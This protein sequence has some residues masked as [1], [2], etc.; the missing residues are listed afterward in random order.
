MLRYSFLLFLFI[1]INAFVQGQVTIYSESFETDGEGTRYTSNTFV[2][3]TSQLGASDFF[4]RTNTNPVQ[5]PTCP[6]PKF[7]ST[8]TGLQGSFFWASEDIRGSTP[9]NTFP[10]GSFVT[11]SFNI[12]GY[13]TLKVS[14]YLATSN[15]NG[16]RW[17]STDSINIKAKI[18]GGNEILVGRFMGTATFGGN[19]IIDANLNGV[20]DAGSESS[21]LCDGVNFTKYTFNIPGTGTNMQVILDFDQAGGTEELAIDLIEV[22]GLTAPG[23]CPNTN[24]NFFCASYNATSLTLNN[25][26]HVCDLV[27]GEYQDISGLMAGNTYRLDFCGIGS[28]PAPAYN[29]LLTVYSPSNTLVG[30]NDD[31]CGDD[32]QFD[33]VAPAS[34]TYRVLANISGNCGATNFIFTPLAITLLATA[35]APEINVKGNGITINDEDISPSIGD[36]TSFG[37]V[38]ACNGTIVKSFR[39]LNSGSSNLTVSGINFIGTHASDYTLTSSPSSP[40]I[41]GD[42]TTFQVTFN[43]SAVGLRT[44]TLNIVNNDGNENPYNFSIEGTGNLSSLSAFITGQNNVL[45]FGQSTG[46]LTVTVSNG[47]ANYNYA[48]SNGANT[49]NTSSVTNTISMLIAGTYTVTVTDANGCTASTSVMVTQPAMALLLSRTTTNVTCIGGSDGTVDLTP[50]GG[51]SGYNYAWSNSATTQD[52]STLSANTYIV[53]VTDANGCTASTN[54]SVIAPSFTISGNNN[55]IIDGDN[56]PSTLDGTNFGTQNINSST[57]Q[58]FILTNTTLA[59]PINSITSN[60]SQF[61]LS[62]VP[63]NLNSNGTEDF[64]VTYF[65]TTSGLH[66]GEIT[67]YY[68]GCASPYNFTVSGQTCVGNNFT[69][70][71]PGTD[72][73]VSSN[74]LNGC[75]PPM[76]NANTIVTV[77]SGSTLFLNGAFTGDIINNGT[78]KGSFNLTGNITNNGTLNPGN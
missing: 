70:I 12:S 58:T 14:L 78:L 48:W 51:T 44:A 1:G 39:I 23:A 20:Y 45:C 7:G 36:N 62:S 74:W 43:P 66:T 31:F 72:P 37:N 68:N 10:P 30:F 2:D 21:P 15:N 6:D 46:A 71:G 54:A 41:P 5:P 57:P 25:R 59:I 33:F 24:P 64:T 18:D 50:T 76:N 13:N 26:T 49:N 73:L 47:T 75:I 40:I 69:F 32:S 27:A 9:P 53:T 17:E 61:T 56:I 67:V 52:I 42:S 38:A 35:S 3:C 11:Q 29:S 8:L 4:V 65:P 16:V 60:A 28:N 19:L 22:T 77:Q 63:S 34:G 55:I